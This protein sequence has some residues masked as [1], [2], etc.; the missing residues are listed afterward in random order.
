MI[1]LRFMQTAEAQYLCNV[2][3]FIGL[4][5]GKELTPLEVCRIKSDYQD[6]LQW[7]EK[8][9]TIAQLR[10]MRYLRE[11]Y[12]MSMRPLFSPH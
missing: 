3:A 7:F 1:P 4:G 10:V 11:Q 9:E 2:Y 8:L 6:V 12:E 5:E